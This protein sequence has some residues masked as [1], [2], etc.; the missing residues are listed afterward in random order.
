LFDTIKEKK[1]ESYRKDFG[2]KWVLLNNEISDGIIK[3]QVIEITES[4]AKE[5]DKYQANI[6]EYQLLNRK[7]LTVKNNLVDYD[8]I[9]EV[10]RKKLKETKI[11]ESMKIQK[12]AYIE[13]N[14]VFTNFVTSLKS[15]VDDFLLKHLLPKIYGRDSK[16]VETFK[17][18]T[19]EW[20]DKVFSYKLLMR[21]RD[22]AIHHDLPIYE[23]K[24]GLT[25]DDK[26][27]FPEI[28]NITPMF[29]KSYLFKNRTLK[30]KL[31]EDLKSYNEVFPVQPI[32]DSIESILDEIMECLIDV[33]NGKYVLSA[34]KILEFHNKFSEP[35]EI[36]YG[37]VKSHDSYNLVKLES[38][39]ANEIKNKY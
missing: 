25:P 21:M 9:I 3:K 28:V 13:V 36:W 29:V 34:N 20:Y 2:N 18:K 11:T 10:Y 19:N 39:N 17:L 14:R 31:E 22:F 12:E 5:L 33:S 23:V 1:M 30:S 35:R 7:L 24:I 15:F 37:F 4:D 32:L 26:T 38:E 27:D 6:F 16:Q 8:R